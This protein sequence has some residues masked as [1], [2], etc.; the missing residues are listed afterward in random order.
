MAILAYMHLASVFYV[1]SERE[2]KNIG[3]IDIELLKEPQSY[4][5]HKE[6]VLEIKYLK[7]T[8]KNE[9]EKVQIKA[10]EQ[11]LNYYRNDTELQSK[12]NLILLTVVVVK[13]KVYVQKVEG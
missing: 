1:R 2:V 8:E 13:S 4:I 6:F 7:E 11:L 12:Q 9:L 10:K 5:D 3:Y